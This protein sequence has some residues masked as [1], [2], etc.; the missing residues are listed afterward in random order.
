MIPHMVRILCCAIAICHGLPVS[1]QPRFAR[2]DWRMRGWWVH[3]IP[4]ALFLGLFGSTRVRL[5]LYA[6]RKYQSPRALC[7][8]L[9][10]A[11]RLELAS[12]PLQ[13]AA[14]LCMCA[15]VSLGPTCHGCGRL[16]GL[17][18]R[19]IGLRILMRLG[20]KEKV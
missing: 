19:G 14:E 5:L 4:F 6:L 15:V 7:R 13:D 3:P 20:L 18:G 12:R 9:P 10:S 11:I 1:K 8:S 16:H 17:G 2:R